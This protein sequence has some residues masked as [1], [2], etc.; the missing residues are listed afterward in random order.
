MRMN[1]RVKSIEACWLMAGTNGV[2]NVEKIA[3]HCS[4]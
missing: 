4:K 3:S 2:V 1:S